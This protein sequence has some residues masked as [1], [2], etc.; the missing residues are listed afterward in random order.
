L[1]AAL[2]IV[3]HFRRTRD[4]RLFSTLI[5]PGIGLLGLLVIVVLAII[6]FPILAGSDAPI[7]AGLPLLLLVALAGG[8]LWA[9]YLRR[10]RPE[11]Y[12]GLNRDLERFDENVP[13]A[14]K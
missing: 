10:N 13:E 4:R 9:A 7:I 1:L 5:A 8:L 3:V 11:V 2:A 12:D 14:H 6:N